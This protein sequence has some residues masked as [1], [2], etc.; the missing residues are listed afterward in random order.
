ML[1][2]L[3]KKVHYQRCP[4]HYL[5]PACLAAS[6]NVRTFSSLSLACLNMNNYF[7]C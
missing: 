3:Y 1:L 6:S 7:S 5:G 4:D 2:S